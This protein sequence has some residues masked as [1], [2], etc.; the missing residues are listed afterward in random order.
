MKATSSKF[1]VWALPLVVAMGWPMLLAGEDASRSVQDGVYNR[2]QAS[3]GRVQYQQLCQT[4]HETRE[5]KPGYM[6]AWTGRTAFDL[7]DLLRTTMPEEDPGVGGAE[8]FTDIVAYMFR[9]SE[10]PAGEEEMKSDEESLK[11]ILIEGPYGESDE[12]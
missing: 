2:A 10:L 1:A 9:L 3:R 6:E 11:L 5:F 7:F 4:C 12:R 8:V